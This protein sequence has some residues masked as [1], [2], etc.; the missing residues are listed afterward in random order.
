CT[1]SGQTL[2]C[3]V[4]LSSALAAGAANGAAAFT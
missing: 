1:T 2:T 3:T 4:T